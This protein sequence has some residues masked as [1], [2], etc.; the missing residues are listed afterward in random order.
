M[1]QAL[2]LPDDA[3]KLDIYIG[4]AIT[5]FVL[6]R[7]WDR[8]TSFF[9]TNSK[10]SGND[11]MRG[12]VNEIHHWL[13]QEDPATGVKLWRAASLELT[14]LRKTL[15]RLADA[16]EVNSRVMQMIL[17]THMDNHE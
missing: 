2:P 14:D 3:S 16:I 13:G 10:Q 9:Q 12:Q 11:K 15:D 1:L 17:Q 4:V 5:L 7:L 6:D 8:L